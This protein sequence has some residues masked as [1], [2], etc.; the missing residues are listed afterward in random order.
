MNPV[1]GVTSR[2]SLFLERQRRCWRRARRRALR[3]QRG[4]LSPPRRSGLR[5]PLSA[6]WALLS[7]GHSSCS[8]GEGRGHAA[9][10]SGSSRHAHAPLPPGGATWSRASEG[11]AVRGPATTEGDDDAG[12]LHAHR[13]GSTWAEERLWADCPSKA[14]SA[15][16]TVR[17]RPL[18]LLGSP[19]AKNRASGGR[20]HAGRFHH[21]GH[22]AVGT[23]PRHPAP[24]P[25]TSQHPPPTDVLSRE[26]AW[27]S[28]QETPLNP[29]PLLRRP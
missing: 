7:R 17:A 23:E 11:T 2:E 14:A 29:E 1:L 9:A 10:A 6:L 8:K 20:R 13:C 12:R 4:H 16:R 18:L 22:T 15:V 3:S 28:R 5:C 21:G 24:D 27:G 25:N 26:A 19:E